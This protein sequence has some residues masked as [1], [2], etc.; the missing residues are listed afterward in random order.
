MTVA[1][2]APRWLQ[3]LL[4]DSL[5]A[6]LGVRGD[7]LDELREV[8]SATGATSNTTGTVG[9]S[10][11]WCRRPRSAGRFRRPGQQPGRGAGPQTLHDRV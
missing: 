2:F 6:V 4:A 8:F 9:W 1:A 11:P 10:S 7:T 5:R 3:D